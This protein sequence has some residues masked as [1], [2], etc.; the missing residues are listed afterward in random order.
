M[1]ISRWIPFLATLTVALTR[2]APLPAQTLKLEL[3]GGTAVNFITPLTV[4]QDGYPDIHTSA[5]YDTKP[6]GPFAPYYSWRVG[7][8]NGDDA[9]EF[10][11]IHHRLFLTNPPPEIQYFAIHFGYNYFF[12]GHAWKKGGLIYHLGLGP[13]VTNPESSVRN[14][15]RQEV[16]TGIFD[17]GYYF[18]GIGMEA[19]V[20]KDIYFT[21]N[22]FVVVEG[23]FTA[24]FAWW[25]PIANG[26]ADVPNFALHG[27]LGIGYDF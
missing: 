24:G 17:A 23:A 20:E 13:I 16:G 2:P 6:F 19:A 15:V 22:A 5:N 14:Q 7:L 11:Q 1:K 4:H 25:V 18:S 8:W 9:W 10:S 26:Y 3:M 27:H 21:K 12:F